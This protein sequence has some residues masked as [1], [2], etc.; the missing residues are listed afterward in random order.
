MITISGLATPV[1]MKVAADTKDKSLESIRN[2][3]IHKRAIERFNESAPD[4]ESVEDFINDYDTFSFVMKAY[5]LEDKIYAKGMMKEI[6]ESDIDDEDSLVNRLNDPKITALYKAMDFQ[7][8][9]VTNYNTLSSQWRQEIVDKYVSNEYIGE[10]TD[11]NAN[12]GVI[13][14]FQ[15][16][17]SELTSWYK[18]LADADF[19]EFMRT[20]LNI[21]ENVIYLDVD[22][23]KEIF[24]EK[25]DIE[26]LQD[27]EELER[28]TKRYAVVK[29]ITDPPQSSAL[30]SPILQLISPSYG[31]G[32]SGFTAMTYDISS[33]SSFSGSAY[34]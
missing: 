8:G 4:V 22:K 23:Q 30:Q 3:V 9:G 31:Y 26:D 24:E 2:E 12:L 17:A 25:Y 18:V 13:L 11:E 33:L 10:I 27:P 28:L 19:G 7:A 29:D 32:G 5:G 6:L 34:R 21:P 15:E 20:A 16:K 1:A 14:K